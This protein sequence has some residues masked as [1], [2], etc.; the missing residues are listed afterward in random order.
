MVLLTG[1]YSEKCC[2][3]G[4]TENADQTT[5]NVEQF[6]DLKECNEMELRN[7]I[8]SRIESVKLTQA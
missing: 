3:N 6:A 5:N 2:I 8:S 4:A 7:K 1:I